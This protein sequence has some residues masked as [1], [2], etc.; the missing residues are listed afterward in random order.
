MCC[1]SPERTQSGVRLL[2]LTT[3]VVWGF[4]M[5]PNAYVKRSMCPVLCSAGLLAAIG[6]PL[7]AQVQTDMSFIEVTEQAGLGGA[8][9]SVAPG[10]PYGVMHGGGVAGDF[11]NDGYHDLFILAGGGLPDYLYINNGDGTFSEQGAGWGVDREQYSYGASAADFNNDGYLDIF[12]TSYGLVSEGSQAGKLAL[13][14]NNGPDDD[15]NWSFTDIASQAGVNRLLGNTRDGTSSGWGD[16]DLDGDLDLFITGYN[17]TRACNRVF[18]NDGVGPD[19]VTV[20]T[21]VTAEAGLEMTGIRGFIPHL[22]DMNDDLYPDLILIADSGTTRY[23]LND[24][25]GGFVD[26]SASANGIETANGMGIDVGDVNNDGMLDMYVTSITF[27]TTDGPGNVLLIQQPDGSFENIARDSGTYHGYWGWGTLMNDFDHDRDIDIAETNGFV[28][29][30][31]NPAVLFD[32]TGD[33]S[34]FNEV[35]LDSG[36]I[37]TGQGR[38]MVRLDFDNDGDLDIGIFENN[39]QFRL[40]ENRIVADHQPPPDRAWLRVK[41]DTAARDTLAPGGIGAMVYLHTGGQRMVLPVHAG[42]SYASSSPIEAHAGLGDA[43]SVEILQVRWPDGSFT[44]RTDVPVNQIL[45]VSAPATPVDYAPDGVTDINDVL[46]FLDGFGNAD[47]TVDHNGDL[48][49]D[50]FDISAFLRDYMDAR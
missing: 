23:M 39:G 45:S 26:A 20:F 14:M 36:F 5:Q 33:G 32:N 7:Q 28:G 16:Y 30:T 3:R 9:R 27:P 42:T 41:L 12:V 19:G 24:G 48:R 4:T 22:V 13:Y 29:H 47:L 37:H 18:R 2:R 10:G 21:D 1:L 34:A 11:N 50:F 38:G 17:E 31:S 49:L 6:Q 35:A 40:Y 8:L 46:A 43:E 25:Q 15:G 44:T